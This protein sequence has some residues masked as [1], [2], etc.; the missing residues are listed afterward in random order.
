[1]TFRRGTR[2]R[3]ESFP[4][5][6]ISRLV[7]PTYERA[8]G[9]PRDVVG[10]SNFRAASAPSGDRAANTCW[11][12]STTRKPRL[13]S[14][15]S[16]PTMSNTAKRPRDL[17][18][19]RAT[20]AQRLH[21]AAPEQPPKPLRLVVRPRPRSSGP[22]RSNG[23]ARDAPPPLAG[24]MRCGASG[25]AAC[26]FASSR[27]PAGLGVPG[28]QVAHAGYGHEI[29][30]RRQCGNERIHR[31]VAVFADRQIEEEVVTYHELG[32]HFGALVARW[33]DDSKQTT[34][35]AIDLIGRFTRVQQRSL[36]L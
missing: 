21:A 32:R 2:S 28:A 7:F 24:A 15:P 17:F 34:C 23:A 1:M 29:D 12:S 16:S 5:S 3:T 10:A 6:N 8:S 19:R 35:H 13:S 30:R 26:P 9:F 11:S 25:Y 22:S 27:G 18:P 14:T 4:W 33:R 36:R 31:L 20:T